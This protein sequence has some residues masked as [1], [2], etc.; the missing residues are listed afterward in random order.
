MKWKILKESTFK[1]YIL[2]REWEELLI[3]YVEKPMNNVIST[4]MFVYQ[5]INY[6]F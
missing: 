2:I 5:R 3:F 1:S 6:N 4:Y